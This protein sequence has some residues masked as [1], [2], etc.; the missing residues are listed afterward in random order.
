MSAQEKKKDN[1]KKIEKG[2]KKK[3][4][5]KNGQIEESQTLTKKI[6]A[7]E[8]LLNEIDQPSRI[9][10]RKAEERTTK[11]GLIANL[12]EK[13]PGGK[14]E[15]QGEDGKKTAGFGGRGEGQGR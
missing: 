12:R 10:K 3:K 7:T 8:S 4:K 14:K 2:K 15:N 13:E 5:I 9:Q 6:H 1:K 11:K